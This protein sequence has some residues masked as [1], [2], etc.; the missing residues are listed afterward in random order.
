MPSSVRKRS[1]HSL[2]AS[3]TLCP[4]QCDVNRLEG[5]LGF[6]RSGV[7]AQVYRYAPHHGEEPP[8]SG[9]KG[10]G[11]V[12]FSRCTLAC[13]YCQNYPWSQQGEGACY[14]TERL[15]GVFR[16]LAVAGCHNWN[17]V[18]PTPWLPQIAEALERVRGE[19][20]SLPVVYNTSGYECCE[21]LTAFRSLVDIYLSDLRYSKAATAEQGSHA[22]DYVEKA[23]AA[24]SMMAGRL[25]PLQCDENGVAISGVICRVLVL[26]GFADEAIENLTWLADEVGVAVPVS[27]MAQ[28]RPA[29]RAAG[30]APWDRGITR[31][32]YDQ[33]CQTVESL[34][35]DT[36]WI[37]EFEGDVDEGLLGHTMK[38]GG[39]EQP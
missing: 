24:F 34:G 26:P 11:T 3:C 38:E 21:T 13:L 7:E 27:V 5:Q 4:R 29:Y 33:V 36:G 8:I 37:Q 17:L 23:R 1:S 18:S 30:Q 35:F 28:Y 25:G 19:G 6:C 20:L 16:E 31:H 2:L 39:F 9:S 32:E 14:D 12:F 22:R 15:A 10:S